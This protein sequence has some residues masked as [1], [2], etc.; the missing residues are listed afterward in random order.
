VARTETGAGPVAECAGLV[1]IYPTATGETHALRGVDAHFHAHTVTALTG[2]SGSGKSTLLALLALRDR[3]SGGEVSVLGRRASTLGTQDRLALTR[4]TIAWVPQRP[5]D[6]VFPHL[7]AAQNVEQAERW[8]GGPAAEGRDL[9]GRLGLD[10]VVGVR[11]SLLSGGEQQRLALA[12][13]CVGAP[14][15]ILCDEPT[16]ELDEATAAL[17]LAELRRAAAAGSAVVV[18]TH[19]PDAVATS[20]RVVALRHGVMAT[21]QWGAATARATIDPAGRLQLPP[22][23]LALFPDQRAVVRVEDGRVVLQPT[24]D[25]S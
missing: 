13:A 3:P 18:A 8:R 1:R 19:D 17:A 6:G 4:R 25:G 10:A 21:E 22:D 16:A 2:P 9:L 24:G 11:A 5:T 12:C 23:A 14:P 20:D 15:L 7:T